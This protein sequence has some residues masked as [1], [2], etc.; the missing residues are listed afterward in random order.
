MNMTFNHYVK[1]LISQMDVDRL[2][3]ADI[4]EELVTHLELTKKQ[5]VSSGLNEKDAEKKAMA[6]FGNPEKVGGEM[7]EAMF[8][9]RRFILL[10]I[11][12]LSIAYSFFAYSMQL[13]SEGNAHH[14]WLIL[15][16]GL[17]LS[18][19]MIAEHISRIFR[20]TYMKVA[21]LILHTL[22]FLY[23][24]FLMADIDSYIAITGFV[25]LFIMLLSIIA[26][27]QLAIYNYRDATEN[28]PSPKSKIMIHIINITLGI[29]YTGFALF[30]IWG[31]LMFSGVDEMFGYWRFYVLMATYV[32]WIVSY[33]FQAKY[34]H[35]TKAVLWLFAAPIIYCAMVVLF[36]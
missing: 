21:I 33:Y 29:V 4:Y 12:Y 20:P 14:I 36:A 18:I 34:I 24:S 27:Y 8:P 2:D 32:V 31:L 35:R 9:M 26:I 3:E 19:W 17:S 5:F 25:A 13:F 23:G 15:A 28:V 6:Q 30:F 11:A 10:M 1:Q 16:I 7:Q 22:I